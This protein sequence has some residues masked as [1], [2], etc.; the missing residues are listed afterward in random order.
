MY[1][2]VDRILVDQVDHQKNYFDGKSLPLGDEIQ[3]QEL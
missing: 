1:V 3:L 2:G